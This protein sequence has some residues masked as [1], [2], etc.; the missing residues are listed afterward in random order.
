MQYTMEKFFVIL[1]FCF[2][3]SACDDDSKKNDAEKLKSVSV[4]DLIGYWELKKGLCIIE[5]QIFSDGGDYTVNKHGDSDSNCIKQLEEPKFVTKTGT[6]K[7]SG[8]NL[9]ITWITTAF[10]E[11]EGVSVTPVIDPNV[12]G[13]GVSISSNTD[14]T[15]SGEGVSV[16]SIIDPNIPGEGVSVKNP[17]VDPNVPSEVVSVNPIVSKAEL[18]GNAG[19]FE[20]VSDTKKQYTSIKFKNGKLC[21]PVISENTDASKPESRVTDFSKEKCFTKKV[22]IDGI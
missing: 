17:I 22:K 14:P 21:L 12:P 1:F 4:V 9:D 13:E 18:N 19:G 15:E 2:F 5:Q 11:G 10:S 3:I 20:L 6:Y 7:L 8:V 16:D